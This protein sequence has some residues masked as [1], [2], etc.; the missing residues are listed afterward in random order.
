M[1]IES[2]VLYWLWLSDITGL[3]TQRAKY[4]YHCFGSSIERLYLAE[5]DSLKYYELKPSILKQ[6][7]DKSLDKAR[8]MVKRCQDAE[9]EILTFQDALYPHKLRELPDAPLLLYYKGKIPQVDSSLSLAMLGARKATPYGIREATEIALMLN[10][11]K[12]LLVTG[13]ATGIDC[14]TI[15]GALKGGNP[16]I[17]VVAGGVDVVSPKQHDILY[18][19]V[20]ER[21]LLISAFPPK[22]PPYGKNFHLRNR[23]LCGLANGVFVVECEATG[24]SMKSALIAKELQRDL[25][26]LPTHVRSPMTGANHLIRYYGGVLTQHAQDILSYYKHRYPQHHL[27]P[28][29]VAQRVADTVTVIPPSNPRKKTQTKKS[30]KNTTTSPQEVPPETPSPEGRTFISLSQQKT[31]LSDDQRVLLEFLAEGD[32]GADFLVETSEIP[33]KRVISALTIL[34]M[35]GRIEE[36]AEGKYHSLVLLE[37][38]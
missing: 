30:K 34:E 37:Q 31:L 24:G 36:V 3:D 32:Y 26:A 5:E 19:D 23:I 18:H 1:A 14:A 4:L 38:T 7:L 17:S 29:V 22:T 33:I 12:V 21:G 35:D 9:Q 16:L 6:L 27:S 20:E 28:E 15:R 25:F 10:Q 11:A 2:S 13:M 8:A